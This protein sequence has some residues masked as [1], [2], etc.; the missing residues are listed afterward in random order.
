MTENANPIDLNKLKALIHKGIESI[1]VDKENT[2]AVIM[3]GDTGVGK[4]TIMSFMAGSELVVR[5]DG[6]KAILDTKK[7]TPIKIGHEKYSETSIPTK[8]VIEKMAF[9]DCPG[10][11]DNKGE[12]Y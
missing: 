3:I 11:K 2:Q 10:F 8:I 7:K 9:Y 5:F 1:P 6:L 4:S 12:E